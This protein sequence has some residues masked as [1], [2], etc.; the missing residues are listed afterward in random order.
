MHGKICVIT[1]GTSGIGLAAAQAL[2]A[3]G[4]RIVLVGRDRA[5]GEAAVKRVGG[6]T[7][8]HY[9]DLSVIAG[10]KQVAAEIAA[11]EPKIDVLI[12]NA[13][14]AF[15]RRQVTA[16]GIE[17][18]FAL[19]HLSYFV[20]TN[21]LLGSLKAA[22]PARIVNVSSVA[23]QRGRLDFDDLMLTR[24]YDGRTA[25]GTSKLANILFT[26]ELSRRLAGTRVTANALHPGIVNTRFGDNIGGIVSLIIGLGKM[27]IGRTPEKGGV[28]GGYFVDCKLT[29][30]SAAAQ[31]DAAARRLWE[32]SVRLTGAGG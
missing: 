32:E 1:G 29:K 7:S 5:R 10:M 3:K 13:G 24:S 25:Y 20:L 30:P 9:G 2:A 6:R 31:D 26:R 21:I 12:N 19:N 11:A 17:Q 8:I 16:D 22:P 28:T 15:G 18:T 14:A 23:H 4:A 27:L